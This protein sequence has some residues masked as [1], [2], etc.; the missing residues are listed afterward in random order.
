MTQTTPAPGT[1][2][3]HPHVQRWFSETFGE[4]TPIQDGGWDAISSGTHALLLAPTG[5]GKTLASFLWALDR[6]LTA[7]RPHLSPGVRLL[8][9]SPLK[10][11]NYDI[12]RNLRAPLEGIRLAAGLDGTDLTEVRI[13]VRTGDTSSSTRASILR[14][15]PDVLITTPESL[16]LMLTAP[17][18]RDVLRTV[19]WVIVDEIHSIAQTKRGTHLALSLERVEAL[20][21]PFQRIGL[22]ATARPPEAVARLLG[23]YDDT[24]SPRR[25][26]IVDGDVPREIDLRVEFVGGR[27]PDL[28]EPDAGSRLNT[29]PAFT[30]AARRVVEIVQRHNSTL[31]FTPSRGNVEQMVQ[32]VNELAGE[33]LVHAHHGSISHD[34]RHELEQRLKDGNVRG[35]VCTSSLEMGIDMGAVDCIVQYSSPQATTAGLQ[36]V[37]RSGHGVGQTSRGRILARHAIDLLECAAVAEAMLEGDIEPVEVPDLCLDVLAQHIVSMVAVEPMNLTDIAAIVR[38]AAPYARLSDPQ[39]QNVMAMLEGEFADERYRELQP[40]VVVDSATGKVHGR[41]GVRILAATNGGTIPDRGEYAVRLDPGWSD[42]SAGSQADS[43][44]LGS[45]DEEFVGDIQRD[46]WPFILGASTWRATRFDHSNVFVVPAPG[47]P[48]MVAFWNGEKRGRSTHLGRRVAR[49]ARAVEDGLGDPEALRSELTGSCAL[50]TEAANALIAYV[51]AQREA[52]GIVPSDRAVPVEWYHD[53]IGDLR[54]VIHSLFGFQVNGAWAHAVKPRIRDRFGNLDPQV[55]W[56]SDGVIIRLPEFEGDPDLGFLDAVDAG[57]VHELLIGELA[58]A[59]MYAWRFRE[60]AQRALLLP[61][62]SP[63]RRTPLWLQRQRAADLLSVVRRKDG[64]PVVQ[65]AVREC[66]QEMWDVEGLRAV[67]RGIEAGEIKRPVLASKAPSPFASNLDYMFLKAFA[68]DGDAP[69]GEC[70][71]AYLAL[72]RDL[73][74]EVLRVEE[75]RDLLDPEVID[76]VR[77]ELG[78]SSPASLSDVDLLALLTDLGDLAEE[79]ILARSTDREATLHALRRL[80]TD[81]RIVRHSRTGRWVATADADRTLEHLLL[82]HTEWA[83]PVSAESLAGRYGLDAEAARSLLSVQERS[84]RLVSGHYLAGGEGREWCRPDVLQRLHR[85][86]L[87]RARAAVRPVSAEKYASFL[88]SLHLDR[89][90]TLEAALGSLGGSAFPLGAWEDGLLPARVPEYTP[91]ALD[92]VCAGGDWTWFGT[93]HGL[94]AVAPRRGRAAMNPRPA[95][96]PSDPLANAILDVLRAGGAWFASD[97]TGHPTVPTGDVDDIGRTLVRLVWSGAVASDSLAGLRAA[98]EMAREGRLAS[99]AA[100]RISRRSGA[101]SAPG[102]PGRWYARSPLPGETE[103]PDAPLAVDTLLDRYGIACR[104][105]FETAGL[106]IGW[107]DLT[108]ELRM[109]TIRGE[110]VQ[111]RFVERLDGMQFARAATVD[112]LRDH[113]PSEEPR[114]L[115]G[116]DPANAW[117]T[118]FRLPAEIYDTWRWRA[119]LPGAAVVTTAGIPVALVA[120]HGRRLLPADPETDPAKVFTPDV[121]AEIARLATWRGRPI[122]TER[123]GKRGLADSDLATPFAEAG[124]RRSGTGFAADP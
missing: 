85:L 3:F 66:Y 24:G 103:G 62:G 10:A 117:G 78:R 26:E 116:V 5:S 120:A 14:R 9:I 84:G 82:R 72:D 52:L 45:L 1:K 53:E 47:E 92:A 43:L 50:D 15:P 114:V 97:L 88:Q 20:A 4:P 76:E 49:L 122:R 69:R 106:D 11:L 110:L 101:D 16:Y 73:L 59:P 80:A 94:V 115:L 67:L 23:G 121:L 105:T 77:A 83:G 13:G 34:I 61:K 29:G 75:L 37:G 39:L 30:E 60:S 7:P 89:S 96:V 27:E 109:R 33:E 40:R 100:F 2:R 36:R 79:E 118:L 102:L 56:T 65:E 18:A 41:K 19:E 57:S 123:V 44:R 87:A 31:V 21:G 108:R 63:T 58:D 64:F 55:T 17:K 54:I 119:R 104:R 51:A 25:V 71:A 93:G 6:L 70:R 98:R 99:R 38:R 48:G 28:D 113:E 107:P 68:E 32:A 22:S 124:W 95:M 111:G 46:R 74:A 91:P 8:Y 42:D 12:E 112:A 35:L 81:G 86:S 90:T